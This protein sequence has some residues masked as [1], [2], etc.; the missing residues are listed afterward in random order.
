MREIYELS[1][2]FFSDIKNENRLF[3]NSDLI[4]CLWRE[5]GKIKCSLTSGHVLITIDWN[6]IRETVLKREDIYL[7]F[8]LE[9][10]VLHV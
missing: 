1:D 3:I 6:R 10:I 4:V 8:S 9:K 5:S 2:D 7:L